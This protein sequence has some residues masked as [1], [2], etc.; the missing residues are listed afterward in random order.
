MPTPAG[1]LVGGSENYQVVMR[2]GNTR[3]YGWRA[4]RALI[5]SNMQFRYSDNDSGVF[6]AQNS[7][8]LNGRPWPR[9]SNSRKRKLWGYIVPLNQMWLVKLIYQPVNYKSA[10]DPEIKSFCAQAS[11]ESSNYSAYMVV[12]SILL[13]CPC[14]G[15]VIEI[16]VYKEWTIEFRMISRLIPVNNSTIRR[17]CN[18][19]LL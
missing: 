12:W 6:C 11:R 3:C 2:C 13:N 7:L 8:K 18:L 14:M 5:L 4:F 16:L 19:P 17:S 10:E 9:P 1:I 15:S